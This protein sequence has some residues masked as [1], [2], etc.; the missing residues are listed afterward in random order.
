[1][2]E[3]TNEA[4]NP[5]TALQAAEQRLQ[6]Q[7]GDCGA[8]VSFVGT[9]RDFNEGEKVQTL[10]LE[11]YP[12]MTERYLHRI[13]AQAQ[14]QWELLDTLIIHRVGAMQP[15]DTIVL[16]AAWAAHRAPAFAACSYLIETLKHQA[17]F[18]KRETLA[19]GSRWVTH[20]TPLTN[21]L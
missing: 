16:T 13:S 20:N 4:F 2:I 9:M 6:A 14:A 10:W 18:W 19:T 8:L 3:I 7:R 17:P 1:M 12:A 11:H 21:S 15:S 5:W